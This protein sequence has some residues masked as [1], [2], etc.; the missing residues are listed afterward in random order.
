M[1]VDAITV[2][3]D[4]DIEVVLRYLRRIGDLPKNLD[5]LFVVDRA[6]RFLGEL[7]LA[8]LLIT[9]PNLKVSGIMTKT[10]DPIFAESSDRDVATI[11]SSST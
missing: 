10:V 8:T 5:Q 2:R 7:Q 11:L 3:S 1:S 6:N 4:V 9:D